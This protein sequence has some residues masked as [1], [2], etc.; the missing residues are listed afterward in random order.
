MDFDL[1]G[2]SNKVITPNGDGLNDTVIFTFDNPKQ[3]QATGK[4]FDIRGALV[5]DMSAGPL[6]GGGS[7]KWDGKAGGTTVSRGVYIYQIEAEDKTFN[8]TVLVIR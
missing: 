8:G 6:G 2:V 7:L 4:I 3:S 1:A 5:A